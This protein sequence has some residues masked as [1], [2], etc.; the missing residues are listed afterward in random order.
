MP[1]L[2]GSVGWSI[3]PYTKRLK[4]QSPVRALWEAR[5]QCFSL[6]FSLTHFLPFSLPPFLFFSFSPSPCLSKINEHILG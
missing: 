2:G 3:I 6:I 1:G 4:V 5:D